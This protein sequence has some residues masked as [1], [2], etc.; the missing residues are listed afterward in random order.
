MKNTFAKTAAAAAASVLMIFGTAA[1]LFAAETNST[2]QITRTSVYYDVDEFGLPKLDQNSLTV[3]VENI[4]NV[5]P[6]D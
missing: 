4:Y 2:S 6:G 1:P 3:K 5:C